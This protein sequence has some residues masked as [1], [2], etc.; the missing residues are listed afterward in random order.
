MILAVLRPG[1]SMKKTEKPKRRRTDQVK[2]E[3]PCPEC[4]SHEAKLDQS[5]MRLQDQ[6]PQAPKKPA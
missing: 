5:D 1:G 3:E 6:T 2:P 4:G